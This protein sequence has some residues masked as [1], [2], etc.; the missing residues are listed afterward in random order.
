MRSGKTQA[1]IEALEPLAVENSFELVD[2]ELVGSARN[3]LLRVLLDRPHVPDG[4][5]LD[6]I[7]SASS[8]I[9]SCLDALDPVKG[10]YTLEVS[11]PGIDRPLRTLEHF[12]RFVGER[13]HVATAPQ[14]AHGG[15]AKWTG[16]L[17][18]VEGTEVL[19]EVDGAVARL[20]FSQIRKANLLG[21][22]DFTKGSN[23]SGKES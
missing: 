6:D 15:R 12:K 21:A 9:N 10:A 13:A 18:G 8:W 17:A 1:I 2:V 14:T 4:P 23:T 16:L 11:S 22:I 19:L 3:P 20:E 5:S 7:A